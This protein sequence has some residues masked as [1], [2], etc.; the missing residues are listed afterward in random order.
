MTS[1]RQGRLPFHGALFAAALAATVLAACGSSG[2]T[3]PTT[4]TGGATPTA[5][6]A[7]TAAPT[8][9]GTGPATAQLTATGSSATLTGALQGAIVQ[10]SLP[11]VDG[12]VIRVDATSPG[13]TGVALVLLIRASSVAVTESSG[14]GQQFKSRQFTG[15]G[16]SDY[17]D[18]SGARLDTQLTETTASGSSAGTLGSVT[19]LK[20]TIA[21]GEFK[22]GSST[23][24]LTGTTPQGD[25]TGAPDTVR[26]TCHVSATQGR[27]VAIVGRTHAGS[28]V[29]V[30]FLVLAPTQVSAAISP[31]NSASH[32]YLAHGGNLASVS[33]AGGHVDATLTEASTGLTLHATGDATCGLSTTGP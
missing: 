11:Q 14:S 19:S 7:A 13:D 32:F 18:T 23:V 17:G 15:S 16:V 27:N 9:S 8:P 6:A 30:F 5:T 21:C 26:V 10:C 12:T 4:P 24:V 28:T 25:I 31:A 20:G 33:A 3:A 1:H 22:A 29:A 2:T